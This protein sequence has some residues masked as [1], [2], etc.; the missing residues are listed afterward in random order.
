MAQNKE[1]AD[2]EKRIGEAVFAPASDAFDLGCTGIH[3][4]FSQNG[5]ALVECY[6][7]NEVEDP[8]CEMA[9]ADYLNDAA[10]SI[11][12]AKMMILKT[13]L[14]DED[15]VAHRNLVDQVEAL[16]QW[17]FEGCV[18]EELDGELGD[19]SDCGPLK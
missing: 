9:F 15:M 17:L 4:G 18:D 2:I 8:V 14:S 12:K 19:T 7:P 13:D 11:I 16:R 10:R 3:I 1:R 5:G 6:Y